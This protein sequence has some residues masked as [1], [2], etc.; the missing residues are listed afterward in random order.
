MAIRFR[1]ETIPDGACELRVAD[2]PDVPVC[3]LPVVFSCNEFRVDNSCLALTGDD[4]E[5][6]CCGD[7]G[8]EPA[9]GEGLDAMCLELDDFEAS[10][11]PEFAVN[12]KTPGSCLCI[13]RGTDD[14]DLLLGTEE[15]D[16]IFRYG[17]DDEI[18]GYG[19]DDYI[20]GG[21]GVDVISSGYGDDRIFG[22][23]GE[24]FIFGIDG[25]D[26][27]YGGSGDDGLL[28]G[29]VNDILNGGRGDDSR[30]RCR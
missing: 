27:L 25:D 7:V 17:G 2:G 30:R 19:G 28:G 11:C 3:E 23:Q 8:D 14:D 10:V 12:H 13:I 22:D 26:K 5:C 4:G 1:V 24:D 21:R 6:R 15:D 9:G 29:V 20:Y 18:L 16:L